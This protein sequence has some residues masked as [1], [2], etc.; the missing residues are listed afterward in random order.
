MIPTF[1]RPYQHGSTRGELRI[2]WASWDENQFEARSIKWAY[3]DRDG[4]ISRGCPEIPLDMLAD[5]V[6]LAH[7]Q[8][9]LDA[10]DIARLRAAFSIRETP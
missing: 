6:I 7:Q 5:L 10:D 3:R 4:K 2:G 9:E 8:G 1:K